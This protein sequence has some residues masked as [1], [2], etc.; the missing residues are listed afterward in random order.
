MHLIWLLQGP[1]RWSGKRLGRGKKPSLYVS[2]V[3][4]ILFSWLNA[5]A[6]ERTALKSANSL[7][8]QNLALR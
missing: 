3:W 8:F 7:I 1:R 2:S 6:V 4:V 5:Y